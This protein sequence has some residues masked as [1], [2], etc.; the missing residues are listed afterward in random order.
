MLRLVLL[1]NIRWELQEPQNKHF[2]FCCSDALEYFSE[3]ILLCNRL[4]FYVSNGTNRLEKRKKSS[5]KY[6]LWNLVYI[7]FFL[8]M[9]PISQVV[10]SIAKHAQK[11]LCTRECNA[12]FMHSNSIPT[13]TARGKTTDGANAWT[14]PAGQQVDLFQTSSATSSVLKH[15]W[16]R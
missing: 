8:A 11:Y 6:V 13:K 3:M 7:L 2:A 15:S 1:K 5:L 4:S 14:L 16:S 9:P 12:K 10:A